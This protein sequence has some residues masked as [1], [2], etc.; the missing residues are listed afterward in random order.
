M[1][2]KF[3]GGHADGQLIDIAQD[4][5]PDQY[6]IPVFPERIP[7][8]PKPKSSISVQLYHLVEFRDGKGGWWYEYHLA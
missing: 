6:K 2:Y 7:L 8:H 4:P 1:Q 5:P 3:V